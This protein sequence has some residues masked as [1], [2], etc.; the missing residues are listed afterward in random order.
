M[1]VAII[2]PPI[3]KN[4]KYPLLGQNRQFR[5][6]SAASTVKIYPVVP[7]IAA[8][9]VKNAGFEVLYLDGINE[10]LSLE[11]FNSEL[12]GF[13]PDIA[14]IETKTPIVK[15]HWSYIDHL[16]KEGIKTVLVGDHV[17]WNPLESFKRSKV[18]Y[19]STGGDYDVS[20]L[21]IVK[22]LAQGAALC[23]GI[24]YRENGEIKNTGRHEL[25][26]D[27]DILPFIDRDL[28]KWRNY[29]E[30]YLIRPVTYIMSG[31]GCG[32]GPRGTGSCTFC[33]WQHNLWNCTARL[34]SPA[35]VAEEIEI[36]VDKYKVKE[37]F[38]DNE[39]GAVW[40][41]E[42]LEEFSAEMKDRDLTGKVILSSNA[43]ADNLDAGTCKLLKSLNYRLLK[44]G[45]ESGCDNTLNK[46]SKRETVE[47]IK[48]GVKNAK[49]AGLRVMLTV[50]TGYPWETEEDVRQTY[51]V[52]NELMNYKTGFGDALQASVLVTY[53]GTP[54][55]SDAIKNDW[56]NAAPEEYERYDM[57]A[58]VLRSQYD[59]NLWCDRMWCVMKEK[60]FA[61][62]SLLTM[63]SLSDIGVAYRGLKSVSGHT[64]D[65]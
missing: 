50:M 53:P 32:G 19:V 34:R 4:G 60:K 42:W 2:Y 39:S 3:T 26:P 13:N 1:K 18:D 5:Y 20:F 64:K 36:L 55:Y 6:S 43:R 12:T 49:D 41:R 47:H 7:S 23:R 48:Q 9:L 11:E 61:L 58:P 21:S 25:I 10:R 8:T 33:S 29:G 59:G 62:K 54:L 28:T 52:V 35:N 45:L 24:W 44:V 15:D 14:M 65:F 37:I 51:Q 38:D 17:S 30:A 27:L 40:N 16:N 46:L 56:F 22:H 31:R 63:R 57:S